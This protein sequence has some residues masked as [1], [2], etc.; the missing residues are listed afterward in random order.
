LANYRHDG[1]LARESRSKWLIRQL[2]ILGLI[3]LAFTIAFV[4]ILVIAWFVSP[5]PLD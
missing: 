3:L 2:G 5:P 1:G 4:V